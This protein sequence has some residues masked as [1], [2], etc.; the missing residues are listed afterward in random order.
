MGNVASNFIGLSAFYD[1][2]NSEN[3]ESS[4]EIYSAEDSDSE[5]ALFEFD[6]D[7]FGIFKVGFFIYLFF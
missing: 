2:E 7:A 4:S 6:L 3:E 5:E 1:D